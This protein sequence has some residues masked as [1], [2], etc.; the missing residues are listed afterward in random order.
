[1]N[2][3]TKT[4]IFV[5][6]AAVLIAVAYFG[7]QKADDF[8]PEAILGKSLFPQFTDPLAIKS[9]EIVKLDAS[10]ERN[11]FRITEVDGIW[12]IPS[13]DNYPADAKDQMGKVAEALT[14]LKV[15]NVI[16]PEGSGVDSID[17][18]KQYGVIDPVSDSSSPDEGV[19]ISVTLGGADNT[20]LVN[21]IVGKAVARRQ[22]QDIMDDSGDHLRYV[23]IANQSPVY[24]VNIDPSVFSTNFDQ[25]IEKNLL[26]ISTFDIKEFLVDEYS[27]SFDLRSVSAAFTGDI[28]LSYNASAVGAEKWS[29]V[30]WS[31][32]DV[33]NLKYNERQL[34]PTKELDTDAL[35]S[36]VSAL[37]DLKIV[38]VQKKPAKF[39]SALRE[40]TPFEN[41]ELD[42]AMEASMHETGFWLVPFADLRNDAR[43]TK[44]QLLSNEGELQ[45]RLKDGIVYQL[46]FGD[47]TGTESEIVS[48]D[49][50][51]ETP[52][53]GVNRYFFIT[54]MFDSALISPPELQPMPELAE[55]EADDSEALQQAREMVEKMNQREQERYD[56]EVA[57]G[58]KRASELSARFADWYYVI[59]EDVYKKIHLMEANVFRMKTEIPDMESPNGLPRVP[60]ELPDLPEVDFEFEEPFTDVGVSV[61]E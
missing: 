25:W 42:E 23:R 17:F 61:S 9:L 19:G 3:T 54:A 38:S 43:Q 37:N 55:G 52:M 40:G 12:S 28:T 44:T 33:Q 30:R 21:L 13:H 8:K 1:M 16:Q 34:D 24:E 36:M 56:D 46:R 49:L 27:I 15:L 51:D 57:V 59:A 48:E 60:F 31:E 47:I 20:T 4:S 10:G 41:I 45:L 32:F 18:Q 35:D 50:P 6:L 14:D 53:M 2:E 7:N 39:A 26:D 29:L 5:L 22:S 58:N 11:E